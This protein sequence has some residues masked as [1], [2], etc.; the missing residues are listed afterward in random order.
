[1]Y[2]ALQCTHITSLFASGPQLILNF[3]E[4]KS[5]D[6]T[7]YISENVTTL[8]VR[9]VEYTFKALCGTDTAGTVEIRKSRI[10]L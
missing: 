10:V 1:M 5:E 4:R 7:E 3:Q 8:L 9:F 2:V 6:Y